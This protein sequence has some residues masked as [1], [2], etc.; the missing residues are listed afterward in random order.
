MF[1]PPAS[2]PGSI[3]STLPAR[4]QP[5]VLS[6]RCCPPVRAAEL[7]GTVPKPRLLGVSV[8]VMSVSPTDVRVHEGSFY[9]NVC[10]REFFNNSLVHPF[11]SLPVASAVSLPSS[12][13]SD[14]QA[15][16]YRTPPVLGNLLECG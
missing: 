13:Q 8:L 16:C 3:R 2:C 6:G 15:C 5:E 7:A 4:P 9:I 12:V 1:G 14:P 10:L 11:V